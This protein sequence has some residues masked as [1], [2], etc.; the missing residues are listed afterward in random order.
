MIAEL[1]CDEMPAPLL[2]IGIDDRYGESG[3]PLEVHKK[4][5]LADDSITKRTKAFVK[6]VPS[7]KPGF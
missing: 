3:A 1:L 6:K 2:R 4:L 5:G 7:Y